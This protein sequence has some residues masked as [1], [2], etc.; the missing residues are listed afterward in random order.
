MDVLTLN[1]TIVVSPGGAFIHSTSPE[2]TAQRAITSIHF[3][4]TG[5]E[6]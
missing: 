1:P 3:T 4:L 6:V 5:I 2:G